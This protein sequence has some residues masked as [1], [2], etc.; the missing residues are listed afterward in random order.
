MQ[1]RQLLLNID[2]AAATFLM[3]DKYRAWDAN[4]YGS[5]L[6][7]LMNGKAA[8]EELSHQMTNL[9]EFF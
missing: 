6:L 2:F 5:K 3:L 1:D 4:N 8:M 7:Q 9:G